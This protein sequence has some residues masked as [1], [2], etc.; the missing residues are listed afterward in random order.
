MK[1]PSFCAQASPCDG[2]PLD[3][4]LCNRETDTG[5][6]PL[7]SRRALIMTNIPTKNAF[8]LALGL[9]IMAMNGVWAWYLVSMGTPGA[10]PYILMGWGFL[11]AYGAVEENTERNRKKLA[12]LEAARAK[13][14]AARERGGM[15]VTPSRVTR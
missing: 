13:A 1:R 5:G 4:M 3:A 8:F 10:L 6:F 9:V 15:S 2:R 7:A 14:L 12:E 11:L